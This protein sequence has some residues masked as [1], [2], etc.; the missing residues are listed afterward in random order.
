MK[1]SLPRILCVLSLL[2][3]GGCSPSIV[4][5]VEGF[6]LPPC[7][8]HDTTKWT[9]CAGTEG[10]KTSMVGWVDYYY[11]YGTNGLNNI[12]TDDFHGYTG[13]YK[14]GKFHGKGRRFMCC[15]EKYVG[16]FRNGDFNGKGTYTHAH[17]RIEK[18]VWKKGEFKTK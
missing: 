7:S 4:E 10:Y 16:E 9:N 2:W 6:R 17:G 13:E 14:D 15:G 11:P 18:G 1:R 3:S 5:G 8:G 12:D